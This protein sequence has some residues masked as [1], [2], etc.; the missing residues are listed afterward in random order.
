MFVSSDLLTV[1]SRRCRIRRGIL[2]GLM[3]VLCS[4][5]LMLAQT[6]EYEGKLIRGIEY[7]PPDQP[8]APEQLQKFQLLKPGEAL[9]REAV[10]A[11]I[12]KLFSS[13]AYTD[14][15]ANIEP[16]ADGVVVR[17]VTKPQEFIGH[18]SVNG[19]VSNPPTVGQVEDASQL[20]LGRPLLKDELLTADHAIQ[21]LFRRNGLYQATVS[22]QLVPS[23]EAQQTAII[24]N[25]RSGSRARF[26]VPAITGDPKMKDEDIIHA[27]HWH[28][29]LIGGWR[30][31]TEV[32]VRNGIQGV[33]KKYQK[34]DRLMAKVQLQ[35]L[36]YSPDTK[37]AKQT[38]NII[39]GP[40][41]NVRAVEAKVSKGTLKKFVP[42]YQEQSVDRD[43]L[44]EGARN[45]RD[46]FQ[47]QG[48]YEAEVDFRQVSQPSQDELTIE[49]VIAKGARYRM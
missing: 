39:A 30:P 23:G 22:H 49:Y 34:K 1:T 47:S 27:T 33:Q 31:V 5:G 11:A 14:V 38:L 44:V 26:T 29:F 42:I 7:D 9:H 40:K 2:A 24:F 20:E 17:F 28:R 12:D 8:L 21:D 3:A 16:R 43:L 32:R 45:L 6:E 41:V 15:Q 13:G 48:Y 46:Y 4:F 25:V 19:K 18:V 36:D 10:A 37:T 35:S